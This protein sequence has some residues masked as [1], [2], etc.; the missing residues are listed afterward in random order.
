MANLEVSKGLSL[1]FMQ[2]LLRNRGK[3][4]QI[5]I[6]FEKTWFTAVTT[7]EAPIH[8]KIAN[9]FTF[10]GKKQSRSRITLQLS[11]KALCKVV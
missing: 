7:N 3:R 1:T 5:M 2:C 9:C 4:D 8:E 10:R 11:S 6:L